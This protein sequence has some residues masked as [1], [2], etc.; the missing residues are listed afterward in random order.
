LRPESTLATPATAELL[1]S[2]L[3]V[4]NVIRFLLDPIV[5]IAT[6]AGTVWAHHEAFDSAYLILSLFVFS[7]TFPG[8]WHV[9]SGLGKLVWSVSTG[10]VVV[11]SV[12]F[13]FGY[14]TQ[15]L[16]QYPQSVLAYWFAATFFSLTSA[17]GALKI[18]LPRVLAAETNRRRAVIVGANELGKRLAAKMHANP[19]LGISLVGFI[20]DRD[21]ERRGELEVP[22]L[23]RLAE[24][25]ALVQNYKLDQIYLALP[26]ASQPRILAVLEALR[27]TTVSIYFVPD[28]F[29]A[30]LI[31]ARVDHVD[32]IPVVAVCESPFYGVNGVTKRLSDILLAS[33]I[34]VLIAPLMAAL[35]IGV[36]LSSPGPV[37]F[38][39][40][41]YGL[42]G[43][44]IWIYKFRSMTV[45]EDGGT[46]TQATRNDL[47]VTRLGA[48]LRKYSLDEL[49]QFINVLQG[50]MSVVGPRPHAV[51]HN[52]M[53]RK[54]IKG[55][56]V[57]HKV[58]PGV[59]GW[60]QVNGLRGE[61]DTLDKMKGR[62]DYD[63]EYL[64]RWSL[65]LDLQ[66]IARTVVEVVVTREVY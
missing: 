53:Y 61:T 59:T 58:R 14:A 50:R 17:H 65:G 38:R 62:V 56:M 10:W 25:P 33:A 36:K 29:V 45:C 22:V 27:D 40:R 7:L 20:D 8:N 24:L 52:E 26:M 23:G 5:I 60:A 4:I 42:D 54:L 11:F 57:R 41:R 12:L 21:R 66:I 64:R 13:F 3:S 15:S 39:Q 48:I 19:L 28:I 44:E 18:V 35:A 37:I 51:A 30:D 9:N 49:P 1:K 55:Y 34:L 6:L 16:D 47:R 46:I 2:R 32:G 63:L 31:Q 43:R